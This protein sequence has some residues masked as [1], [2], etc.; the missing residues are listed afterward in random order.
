MIRR[1]QR[2]TSPQPQPWWPGQPDT[3]GGFEEPDEPGWYVWIFDEIMA[4]FDTESAARAWAARWMT[5][6]VGYY[7]GG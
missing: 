2:A 1:R 5:T 4:G 7:P 3:T 6:V